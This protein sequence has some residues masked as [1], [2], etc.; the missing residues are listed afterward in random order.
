MQTSLSPLITSTAQL[1]SPSFESPFALNLAFSATGLSALNVTE[2]LRDFP[3]SRGQFA[4]ASAL[5]SALG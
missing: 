5:V 2:D 3:F 1:L 4:D